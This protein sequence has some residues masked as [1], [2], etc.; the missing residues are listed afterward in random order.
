MHLNV[1]R[2]LER[3]VIN[4]VNP[5]KVYLTLAL[6]FQ[7]TLSTAQTILNVVAIGSC[8]DSVKVTQVPSYPNNA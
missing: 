1:V 8:A 7:V 2:L 4:F 5:S 3:F 6:A